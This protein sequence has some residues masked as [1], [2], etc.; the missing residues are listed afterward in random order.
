MSG[1]GGNT[2]Q[3]QKSDPPA[4]LQPFLTDIAQTAYRNW[5]TPP[6]YFPGATFLGPTEGQIGAF[7]QQ[8]DYS[9]SVF[10]GANAP[11]FGDA[12]NALQQ[13]LQG[14][15]GLGQLSSQI[16][17]FAGQQVRQGFSGPLS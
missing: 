5:Q 12:T 3:V 1:G 15:G 2:T 17:P 14:T 10:G 8:F 11:K 7:G 9:N 4:Y 6:A 13:N 16:T